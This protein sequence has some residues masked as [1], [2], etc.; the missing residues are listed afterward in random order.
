MY[1]IEKNENLNKENVE[2]YSFEYDL[3]VVEFESYI[4]NDFVY[5]PS[6]GMSYKYS[7]KNPSG[8]NLYDT[9]KGLEVD[10]YMAYS[11]I[12]GDGECYWTY[13]VHYSG[14]QTP[15]PGYEEYKDAWVPAHSEF[16]FP[17]TFIE[18]M[19]F[20]LKSAQRG[21]LTQEFIMDVYFRANYPP[22]NI[23]EYPMGS[24]DYYLDNNYPYFINL[25][26]SSEVKVNNSLFSDFSW[27][28]DWEG[29][30]YFKFAFG[31]DEK[32][33][34]MK[35]VDFFYGDNTIHVR[36]PKEEHG[37]DKFKLTLE[38]NYDTS[39]KDT[40]NGGLVTSLKQVN[41]D[42]IVPL[43]EYSYYSMNFDDDNLVS[44]VKIPYA[45]NESG[46]KNEVYTF[47]KLFVNSY[48]YPTTT[49]DLL[50]ISYSD[51]YSNE[52]PDIDI[53]DTATL[54]INGYPEMEINIIE[55]IKDNSL[56]ISAEENMYYD[57]E[58]EEVV[59]GLSSGKFENEVGIVLPWD[60]KVSGT[61]EFNI[62]SN[63]NV[64]RTFN[65]KLEIGS[66]NT[67]RGPGG[68]YEI[69]EVIDGEIK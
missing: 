26:S 27:D 41:Y 45:Y 42:L 47:E 11:V 5:A 61:I 63:T 30:M 18:P 32:S 48:D 23:Y 56:I 13:Y 28:A 24:G 43:G 57:Y 22:A 35:P 10:D 33:I 36:V 29:F 66:N 21:L 2:N 16:Y 69:R 46:L 65:F 14:S 4:P 55:R 34:V 51:G 3:P 44:E 31:K 52:L 19:V 17:Q 38:T 39:Y 60:E 1:L 37:G 6:P 7:I 68:K 53:D 64:P 9:V 8:Y 40:I 50:K 54:K 67:L 12:G 59:F 25:L 15:N 20:E 49:K 58:N 62:V